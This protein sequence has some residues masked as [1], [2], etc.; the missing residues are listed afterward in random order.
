LKITRAGTAV[1]KILIQYG[2]CGYGTYLI[3]YT[4]T[5]LKVS[6]SRILDFN[7]KVKVLDWSWLWIQQ[8]LGLKWND[9][10]RSVFYSFIHKELVQHN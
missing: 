3:Q 4:C 1:D 9:H 5:W 6:K 10:L 8:I 2:P 7:N